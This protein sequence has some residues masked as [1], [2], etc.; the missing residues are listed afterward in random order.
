MKSCSLMLLVG[1]LLGVIALLSG[2]WRTAELVGDGIGMSAN[3]ELP[4]GSGDDG[5][6]VSRSGGMMPSCS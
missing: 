6:E 3:E 2:V 5:T 4:S 1:L